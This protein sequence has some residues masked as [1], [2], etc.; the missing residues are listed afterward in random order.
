MRA[1]AEQSDGAEREGYCRFA[2]RTGKVGL[3]FLVAAVGLVVLVS[4]CGPEHGPG[5][6]GDDGWRQNVSVA[7]LTHEA[8]TSV[9]FTSSAQTCAGV[10]L[11]SDLR[12]EPPAQSQAV[13]V[14]STLPYT[15]TVGWQLFNEADSTHVVS[16]TIL[17]S[18]GWGWQVIAPSFPFTLTRRASVAIQARTVLSG[19]IVP[20]AACVTDTLDISVTYLSCGNVVATAV[21]TTTVFYRTDL[22]L[23]KRAQPDTVTAGEQLT[24]TLTYTNVGHF[25]AKNVVITDFLPPSVTVVYSS[26]SPVLVSDSH[27]VIWKLGDLAPDGKPS[28]IT[29]VVTASNTITDDRSLVNT[30]TIVAGNADPMTAPITTTVR[31]VPPRSCTAFCIY[32]PVVQKSYPPTPD[33]STSRKTATWLAYDSRFVVGYTITLTN[34]GT[35]TATDVRLTDTIPVSTTY[36]SGSLVPVPAC[37]YTSTT[38]QRQVV[39]NGLTIGISQTITVSFQVEMDRGFSCVVDNT[40]LV[41]DGYNPPLALTTSTSPFPRILNGGFETGDLTCWQSGGGLV[42]GTVPKVWK[43]GPCLAGQSCARLGGDD[44]VYS[45]H[46]PLDTYGGIWQT[47]TVPVAS[48]VP[49]PQITLSY[50]VFSHDRVYDRDNNRYYD[51]FEVSVNVPPGAITK[52]D[53]H[54][55]GCNVCSPYPAAMTIPVTGPGLLFCGGNRTCSRP[56]TDVPYGTGW[57]TVTLQLDSG[58]FGGKEITLYMANWNR[59]TVDFN[60]WTYVDNV[61]TNW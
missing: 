35:L 39:C 5:N 54:S 9:P 48:E 12:L 17:S 34:T 16:V 28:P 7:G 31:P 37:V 24:Y 45:G 44:K 23:E 18:Q 29:L 60:T 22:A 49:D 27:T 19:A 51:D 2:G 11:A 20:D 36:V 10:H 58:V 1:I 8:L 26:S 41:Y 59:R 56:M 13:I 52:A 50:R 14:T 53:R 25:V 55:R 6:L 33:L 4:T 40:A 15:I 21:A 57:L 38:T 46:V 32:L 3:A 42:V 61:R 47:F 43:D 30:A